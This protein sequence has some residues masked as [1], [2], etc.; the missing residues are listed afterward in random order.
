M[1]ATLVKYLQSFKEVY[2]EI[3]NSGAVSIEKREFIEEF[4]SIFKDAVG[5]IIDDQNK[6][7]KFVYELR[8]ININVR[9]SMTDFI[10][11]KTLTQRKNT[12][13]LEIIKSNNWDPKSESMRVNYSTKF[14]IQ[15]Q[16]GQ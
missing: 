3:K 16:D 11:S 7:F 1:F 15:S 13:M 14:K 5:M 10:L 4:N 2:D 9:N 8:K 6:F 12:I